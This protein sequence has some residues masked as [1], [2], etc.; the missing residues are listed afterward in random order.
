MTYRPGGTFRKLKRPVLSVSTDGGA[1]APPSGIRLT[2]TRSRGS[3]V[4]DRDTIPVMLEV[5]SGTA[6]VATRRNIANCERVPTVATGKAYHF[7]RFRKLRGAQ[8]P[9]TTQFVGKV[10][11]KRQ[12]RG[13]RIHHDYYSRVTPLYYRFG[14]PLLCSRQTAIVMLISFFS[15]HSASSVALWHRQ[16]LG[17]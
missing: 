15:A 10:A 8:F 1:A 5:S 9:G 16:N 6:C 17:L 12:C 11:P 7:T 13:G 3:A 2:T 4:P 14:R